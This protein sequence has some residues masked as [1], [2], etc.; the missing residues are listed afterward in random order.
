MQNLTLDYQQA[1]FGLHVGFG[2]RPALIL[3]DFVKAYFAKAS[4]LY[5]PDAVD[6]MQAALEASLR[7][8]TLAHKAGLPV[9]L[10]QVVI[11][12]SDL[13][14]HLMYRK[15]KGLALFEQ[16]SQF[17]EFADGLTPDPRDH[18]ITKLYPSAFFG[19]AL[20]SLLV[21]DKV[22]S[23]IITGLST[24]GC[25]RAT[26]NDSIS[27]GFAP[28]VVHDGV[29]DRDDRP[30]QANLFDMGAKYADIVSEDDVARH[31]EKI[32]AAS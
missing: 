30:H 29:A 32:P 25:V 10:T 19:T 20:S 14:S 8:R 16:G 11:S 4:P 1:G 9:F 31:F 5:A 21:A 2:A 13:K 23:L 6:G 7:L 3:I 22:D 18:L 15:S 28:S 12:P 26:C 27:Y 17:A 24:S